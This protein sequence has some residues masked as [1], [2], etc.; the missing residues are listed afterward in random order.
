MRFGKLKP[1]CYAIFYMLF[2]IYY[3]IYYNSLILNSC[4]LLLCDL[5]LF[6]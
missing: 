6:I 3:F 4:V 5:Q 2:C 1:T